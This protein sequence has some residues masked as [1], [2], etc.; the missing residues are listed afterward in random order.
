MIYQT[1]CRY[2]QK[3]HTTG[4]LRTNRRKN[5]TSIVKKTLKMKKGEHC[6][7]KRGPDYVSRWRDRRDVFSITLGHHPEMVT[8]SNRFSQPLIKPKHIVEYNKN[9]SGIDVTRC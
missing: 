6:F 2:K 9:M 5:P 7:A 3:T 8:T 1:C 4:T